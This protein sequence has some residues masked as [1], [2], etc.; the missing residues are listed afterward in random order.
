MIEDQNND[1][2]YIDHNNLKV[3][4]SA[5]I[6]TADDGSAVSAAGI[7]GVGSSFLEV[8]DEEKELLAEMS[9]DSCIGFILDATGVG[10]ADFYAVPYI[11]VFAFDDAGG[12]YAAVGEKLECESG[13]IYIADDMSAYKTGMNFA[14]FIERF[15]EISGSYTE[16]VNKLKA[17]NQKADICIFRNIE[18]ASKHFRI[19][20]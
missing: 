13:V 5:V 14:E 4:A 12:R 2:T 8:P 6:Y 20:R 11:D 3:I 1:I 18:E 19:I 15:S 9:S 10:A 17:A 16:F 7:S